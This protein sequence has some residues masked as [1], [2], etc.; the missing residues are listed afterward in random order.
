MNIAEQLIGP[1]IKGVTG[2]AHLQVA[3]E[4]ETCPLASGQRLWRVG[5]LQRHTC[6]TALDKSDEA[7]GCLWIAPGSHKDGQR[8]SRFHRGRKNR[9]DR[10]RTQAGRQ[11]RHSDA[12]G[13][14]TMPDF[15][16]LD[17]SPVRWQ[18]L[19]GTGPA[20]TL[21]TLRRCRCGRGLQR[22]ST[23]AWAGSS[24]EQAGFRKSWNL[25]RIY[26]MP[27]RLRQAGPRGRATICRCLRGTAVQT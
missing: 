6:L 4:H 5:A 14:G 7:N 27:G 25:N 23:S 18:Q 9:A 24:G 8:A 26:R 17:L 15:Q 22:Q 20:H 16:L 1:N 11:Q 10:D 21:H 13:A 3:R 2:T 12:D 19:E